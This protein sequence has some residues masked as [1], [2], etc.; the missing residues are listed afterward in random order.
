MSVT[1][2]QLLFSLGKYGVG[3]ALLAFVI[4]RNWS[5][6][7][8]GSPGIADT[9]T[10]PLHLLP[11][12]A[13]IVI[14]GA[15]L[16]ITFYRWYLLVLAQKLS[17]TLANAFRLGLVGFFLSSFLPGSIGGDIA[18]AYSIAREQSRR[19]VAV[20]TVLIDRVMGLLGLIWLVALLGV[21]FWVFGAEAVTQNKDLQLIVISSVAIVVAS[22]IFWLLFGILPAWRADRF[23]RRLERISKVGHPAAELW[24][25]MWMYRLQGRTMFLALAMSVVGHVCFVMSFYFSAKVFG[26]ADTAAHLPSL[27][28]HFL[29]IPVGLAIQAVPL[30]P[31]GVGLGE[32]SFGKLYALV[33]YSEANGVL[34]SL[35][36]RIIGWGVGLVGYGVYLRMRPAL[37]SIECED[38]KLVAVEA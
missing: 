3:I 23:A 18:K 38:K 25:A 30:A 34:A 20:A 32:Y 24:R 1:K 29:I 17:F 31:G 37:N 14:F 28:E 15:G 7:P 9:I 8:N 16:F 10:K 33:G 2:R 36:Y 5:P 6:S 22:V 13:A 27:T 26:D 12:L 35:A 19:T 21:G 11:L 4:W